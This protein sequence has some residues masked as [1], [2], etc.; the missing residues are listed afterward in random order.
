MI[1]LPNCS[2]L[3]VYKR[4]TYKGHGLR[5]DL[6]EAIADLKPRFVR[7]PGGCMLHGQGLKN[8]YHWKESVVKLYYDLCFLILH[9]NCGC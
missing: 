7:F 6:A 2:C 9:L 5:K 4:Q 8:I 1:G 3:D